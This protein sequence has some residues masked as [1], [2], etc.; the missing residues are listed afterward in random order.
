MSRALKLKSSS[1][2][3]VLNPWRSVGSTST[4]TR[5]PTDPSNLKAGCVTS[6]REYCRTIHSDT[7]QSKRIF[8]PPS[9]LEYSFPQ[10]PGARTIS[11]TTCLQLNATSNLQFKKS[12]N[13]NFMTTNL[14]LGPDVEGNLYD[15]LEIHPQATSKEVKEAFYRLS[16]IHHPD[17]NKDNEAALERFQVISEA[18]QTLSNPALREKYDKGVL[19]RTSSVAD[20]ERSSHRF[21]KESFYGSRSNRDAQGGGMKTQKT[22]LDQWVTENRQLSFRMTQA[23]LIKMKS[24]KSRAC[25]ARSNHMEHN[26]SMNPGRRGSGGTYLFYVA[27]LSIFFY[28]CTK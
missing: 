6:R 2:T 27:T 25:I 14:R 5:S 21:D 15:H 4:G 18:Y 16:K 11:N 13:L 7:P 20:R 9:F 19:G 22:N 28:F 17:T 12:S 23:K 1:S 8:N 10:C 24:G 3:C 26:P